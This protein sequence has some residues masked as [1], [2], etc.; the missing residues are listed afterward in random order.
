MYFKLP[1]AIVFFFLILAGLFLFK[2]QLWSPAATVP[3]ELNG[4]Q[5]PVDSAIEAIN[6]IHVRDLQ[7]HLEFLADDLLQGRDTGSTGAQIGAR[8]IVTQF[9]R[10]GLQPGAEG[11]TFYQAVPLTRK[12]VLASSQLSVEVDGEMIPLRYGDDFLVTG[13]PARSGVS[14]TKQLTFAAFGITAPEY[15]YNDYE[16]LDVQDKF[17]VYLSGEPNSEDSTFFAG[18]RPSRYSF[19]PGK[20]RTAEKHGASAA[21]GIVRNEQLARFSWSGLKSFLARPQVRLADASADPRTTSFP[22]VILHPEVADLVFAGARS[23]YK[24]IDDKA[25]GGFVEPFAMQKRAKLK[26]DFVEDGVKS[27]NILGFIKGADP[28]LESEVIVFTAHYDHIGIGTPVAGDSVYNGAAD[29]ASGVSGLLELAEAFS[30]L[31][32]PPRRSLLFLATTAEEKGLLGSLYYTLH[33]VF[34]I[35]KTVANFN[36]DMI[37]IIDSTAM[38]VYGIE[39]SS[40]GDKMRRAAKQFGLKIL[41]DDMP[42]QRVF[43]RSDHYNFALQGVPAIF[44]SFGIQKPQENI[45]N[46]FYH[47]PSDGPH[48]KWLNYRTMKRQVQTV[49]QAALWVANADAR[50]EW[51]PGDE[52][53]K[54]RMQQ[55]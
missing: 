26:I 17:S 33:P 48:L 45:F 38:V 13:T 11:E 18:A 25:S 35:E 21:F 54:H 3:E 49:F 55:K 27:D 31:A 47:Q 16:G 32:T 28:Q 34:P 22:G 52:F 15:D 37:G 19:G 8:Y 7:A 42:E 29:N 50:P 41:P 23:S 20:R 43:F 14:V 44:P 4:V 6:S 53:E 30:Q 1:L 12:Q 39:R 5:Q 36:L 51:T 46:E 2:D 40:L 9:Q 10:F 24:D